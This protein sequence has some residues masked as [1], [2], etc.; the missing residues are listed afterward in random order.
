M[1]ASKKRARSSDRVFLNVGGEVFQTTISTLT[2]NSE[3]FSRK[4]SSEWSSD[5]EDE[6]FLDRDA[7]SFRVLLSCMRHRTA[8]LPEGDPLLCTRVLLEAQYL[9]VD[10]LLEHVKGVAYTH[11][12]DPDDEG[13]P[14]IAIGSEPHVQFD[15]EH[16]GLDQALSSGVLPARFFGPVKTGSKRVKQI[17][18]A[19][20]H[21]AIMFDNLTSEV[22]RAVCYALFENERGE[23]VIEPVVSFEDGA[24][25]LCLASELPGRETWSMS[26]QGVRFE[27]A[28]VLATEEDINAQ[29]EEGFC[30]KNVMPDGKIVLMEKR[31][32]GKTGF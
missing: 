32:T 19:G 27:Y 15:R 24:V 2:A 13:I 4:F 7:D 1:S 17:I 22:Y 3:F 12:R 16:G 25:T 6:I 11:T 30:V 21:D 8:L 29:C 14:A 9:G 28:E 20:E 18:P 31:V 23:S 5:A 26:E 10:W